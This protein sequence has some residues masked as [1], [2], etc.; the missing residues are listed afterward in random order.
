MSSCRPFTINAPPSIS[1]I[2]ATAVPQ[3]V[4][5]AFRCGGEAL[6][7]VILNL[8]LPPPEQWVEDLPPE[9]LS[10]LLSIGN[11]GV[12]P[13]TSYIG[14][15]S[16]PEF[17]VTTDATATTNSPTLPKSEP[18]SPSQTQ[19]STKA[20][21]S[22]LSGGIIAAIVLGIAVVFLGLGL[23]A[24]WWKD[25]WKRKL[26]KGFRIHTY[27]HSRDPAIPLREDPQV[28]QLLKNPQRR[29]THGMAW[30]R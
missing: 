8:L 18:T 15:S 5:S 3:D 17:T 19:S 21:S 26:K 27:P 10:Y 12:G 30:H 14:S 22:R 2:I 7:S 16:L 4:Q 1:S 24:Y 23:V 11:E 28:R 13:F 25:S 29:P 6:K 20:P 9:V